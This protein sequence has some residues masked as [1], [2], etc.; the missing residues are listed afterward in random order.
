LCDGFDMSSRDEQ[1]PQ[2][3]RDAVALT[4]LV[5]AAKAAGEPPGEARRLAQERLDK[6][7]ADLVM[8]LGELLAR[9]LA[10]G[11]ECVNVSGNVTPDS[12]QQTTVLS[13]LERLAAAAEGGS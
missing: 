4:T 11:V 6:S 10:F 5:A 12:G 2:A 9:A 3:L 7:G 8:A 1:Q 13:L